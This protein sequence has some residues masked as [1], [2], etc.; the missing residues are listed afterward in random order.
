MNARL[1]T[2]WSALGSP[3]VPGNHTVPGIGTII[4]VLQRHINMAAHY[5]G[6]CMV[7]LQRSVL[8]SATNPKWVITE[9][10]RYGGETE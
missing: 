4:L 10:G 2:T 1:Q 6:D 8:S 9:M 7:T 5:G 3:R